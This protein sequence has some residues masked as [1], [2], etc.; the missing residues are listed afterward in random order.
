[1]RRLPLTT[2]QLNHHQMFGH[3]RALTHTK[4]RIHWLLTAMRVRLII[5]NDVT[6]KLLTA[7][8]VRLIIEYGIAT[9]KTSEL[10]AKKCDLECTETQYVENVRL[11]SRQS[12]QSQISEKEPAVDVAHVNAF[13]FRMHGQ[14]LGGGL[15]LL[16]GQHVDE[17]R[18]GRATHR[19]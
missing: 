12:L 3:T 5:E 15:D 6:T 10:Y 9:P 2:V 7:M 8:F 18:L 16:N 14:C 11:A 13:E 4:H 17:F 1:M 19:R